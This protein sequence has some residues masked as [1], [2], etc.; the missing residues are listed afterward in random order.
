MPSTRTIGFGWNACGQLGATNYL[1]SITVPTVLELPDE[2]K[3]GKIRGA[4]TGHFSTLFCTTKGL[5]VGMG[6]DENGLLGGASKGNKRSS[7]DA[8][9]GMSPHH[10][11]SPTIL[12]CFQRHR[13][14]KVAC[15]AEHAAAITVHRQLLTWGKNNAGQLGRLPDPTNVIEYKPRGTEKGALDKGI[16]A[17]ALGFAHTV[18]L[19]SDGHVFVFGD[20]T[21]GTLGLGHEKVLIENA[22]AGGMGP[23]NRRHG[24]RWVVQAKSTSEPQRIVSLV[25]RIVQV[26]AG[27]YHSLFLDMTGNVWA[28][29]LL[30]YGRLGVGAG[31]PS[32]GPDGVVSKPALVK[33]FGSLALPLKKGKGE[34]GDGL[35]GGGEDHDGAELEDEVEHVPQVLQAVSIGAG[36][37]GSFALGNDGHCYVWGCNFNGQLGLQGA[38][39]DVPEPT[40]IPNFNDETGISIK[41]VAMAEDHSI[42]LS[43]TGNLYASGKVKCGRLGYD[44]NNVDC[45]S[46]PRLIVE[47]SE[48][49]RGVLSDIVTF[50][51]ASGAHCVALS[52]EDDP[53]FVH[54][55]R[56]QVAESDVLL[57]KEDARKQEMEEKQREAEA[58]REQSKFF[59]KMREEYNAE[60]KR[61]AAKLLRQQNQDRMKKRPPVEK[62]EPGTVPTGG[63]GT[64]PAHHPSTDDDPVSEQ[65]I[66]GNGQGAGKG[67]GGA[68]DAKTDALSEDED[69]VYESGSEDD[70]EV[71]A[72]CNVVKKEG[73]L[74]LIASASAPVLRSNFSEFQPQ[75]LSYND[76]MV[77]A[78]QASLKETV[79]HEDEVVHN[80]IVE[81]AP[82]V[83]SASVEH[84]VSNEDGE[85][86]KRIIQETLLG[87]VGLVETEHVDRVASAAVNTLLEDVV[88]SILA[89]SVQTIDDENVQTLPSEEDRQD[90]HQ[91]TEALVQ[92]EMSIAEEE[93]LSTEPVHDQKTDNV[94]E[95]VEEEKETVTEA[96]ADEIVQVDGIKELLGAQEV[97]TKKDDDV[98]KQKSVNSKEK[99]GLD[100][101]S[102]PAREDQVCKKK[103]DVVT[104]EWCG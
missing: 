20:G 29:G 33:L 43:E 49:K 66:A 73:A 50:V 98:S 89:V 19:N 9:R 61:E 63:A 54:R 88:S 22:L 78:L 8:V 92:E 81:P 11:V 97:P 5:V 52:V 60:Q 85:T 38:H 69:Y 18:A 31:A 84:P 65:S 55:L 74:G 35:E 82:I 96:K 86:T 30:Q 6:S 7:G 16:V 3:H 25:V 104:F 45:I 80:T 77:Q 42:F 93:Y 37:A 71:L 51:S 53:G 40:P 101:A 15:G 36:G 47:K 79:Q 2:E 94:A 34:D 57:A 67:G 58:A 23:P 21:R 102:K 91:S 10:I 100:E 24:K 14:V 90:G 32:S 26:A 95:Q 83:E 99:A 13:V 70:E 27:D 62:K 44:E 48:A 59:A 28:C 12:T 39:R 17:V 4:A 1:S 68:E 75:K 87:V 56:R 103:P 76:M 64:A 41:L 72:A 46:Q